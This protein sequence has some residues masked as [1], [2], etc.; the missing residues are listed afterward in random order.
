M[1]LWQGFRGSLGFLNYALRITVLNEHW[2]SPEA[3]PSSKTF[4]D[5]GGFSPTV[6][7]SLDF[8]GAYLFSLF[9]VPLPDHSPS[10]NIPSNHQTILPTLPPCCGQC[11]LPVS[12]LFPRSL[13][14]LFKVTLP[15]MVSISTQYPLKNYLGDFNIHRKTSSSILEA[16]FLNP[17]FNDL[18]LHSTTATHTDGQPWPCHFLS[19]PWPAL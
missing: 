7:V 13:D 15:L 5:G 6:L 11:S 10:L 18:S 4:S 3:L 1:D 14:S 8:K 2:F 19:P 16:Q 17:S 9:L 12:L